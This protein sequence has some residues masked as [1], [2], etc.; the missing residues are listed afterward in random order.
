MRSTGVALTKQAE[1]Q[2]WAYYVQTPHEPKIPSKNYGTSS[3]ER[4]YRADH[5]ASNYVHV[6][7]KLR[8][9]HTK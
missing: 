2:G 6:P 1:R 3:S 9:H 8:I 4:W 7:G 5:V